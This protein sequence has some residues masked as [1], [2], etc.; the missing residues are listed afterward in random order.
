MAE[1][2]GFAETAL[3]YYVGHRTVQRDCEVTRNAIR[4]MREQLSRGDKKPPRVT[5]L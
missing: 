3:G 1:R 5:A 2:R 4:R